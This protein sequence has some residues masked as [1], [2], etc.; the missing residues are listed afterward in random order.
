MSKEIL[1]VVE[2]VSNEKG[3][4]REAIF[5][6]IEQALV[7]ATKKKYNIEEMDARISINRKTGD[8]DT[9]R[10]WTVMAD[11]DHEM[12]AQ[13][14]AIS[15]V[16]E[17]GLNIGDVVEEQI[18]SIEFGRIAAQ[19]AKQVIVQK[20]R[21]AERALVVDAY[22]LRVGELLSGEVKKITRD[23]L[24]VD[25]GNN[26]EG[27]L[28]REQM[29]AKEN[30]RVKERVAS[31][32]Y[33]V[34]AEGRGAQLLLSRTCPEML[35]S[36]FHKEVPEI[37]EE[38]IE[39]KGAARDP[40]IRAKIAVKT[41][42]HRI[43]PVGACV[44]MRGTRVQAVTAELGGERVDIVLWD[45]NTAQFVI[46]ALQ[47]AEVVSI[48]VDEDSHS[49]DVAVESDQL[50]QAIGRSGQNV[51]LASELTGWRLNVMTI[52]DAN[53]KQ[54]TESQRYVD[55][56]VRLL[57]VDEDLAS[58]LVNEG[59]TTLEEVAYVPIEEMLAIEDFDEEMVSSL[60]QR[61]KDAILMQA[62]VSQEKA[63]PADDLL[64]MEGMNRKLAYALAAR[65]VITMEDL[66]EQAIDD[67]VGIDG[68]DGEVAAQLIMKAREPWFL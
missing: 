7:A 2:S 28:A 67:I 8:Y 35:I 36:L 1:L 12:P 4:A 34:N 37:G 64:A 5:Q 20:I 41:N 53:A 11:E 59:F 32:L 46:N 21:E 38:I 62:L 65:G 19:T 50:A 30:F 3:I 26:A 57:E 47:P 29:M 10:R 24:I 14:L 39:I 63:E 31:I 43:D 13:Q 33:A 68:L 61:A 9:F 40:G 48:I 49:M 54:A 16:A 56:F 44:G 58:I 52:D 23:G 17:R 45:D 66:A 15:D 18:P 6:A 25:L 51:R 22:K 60:R 55:E 27:Y 42:D